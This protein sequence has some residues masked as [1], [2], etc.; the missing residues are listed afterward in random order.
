MTHTEGYQ[1]KLV[2]DTIH[3]ELVSINIFANY[4]I[5]YVYINTRETNIV[6]V[7][8]NILSKSD[9]VAIGTQS[10]LVNTCHTVSIRSSYVSM[11]FQTYLTISHS[12]LQDHPI[13]LQQQTQRP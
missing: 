4:D 9:R 10:L 3:S 2:H 13:V 1:A 7:A 6:N 8:H 5:Q 11:V 12:V